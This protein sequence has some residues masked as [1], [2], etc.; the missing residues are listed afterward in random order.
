MLD[1]DT[2][3]TAFED[4]VT[5]VQGG[6]AGVPIN[7]YLSKLTKKRIARVWIDENYPDGLPD[8]TT[9]DPG[10]STS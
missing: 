2:L 9:V 8:I 7:F 6:N 10:T 3:M 5:I 4:F 1:I